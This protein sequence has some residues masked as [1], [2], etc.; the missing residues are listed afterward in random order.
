VTNTFSRKPDLRTSEPVAVRSRGLS[1]R[2]GDN[3]ALE[4]LS[5][6]VPFGAFVGLL[7]P[8]G[9]GKTTS[10]HCLTTLVEPSTG[11]AWIAGHPIRSSGVAIRRDIGVVFQS[12][13]LDPSL[14]VEETLAFAGAIRGLPRRVSRQRAEAMLALFRLDATRRA[15][16]ATL[17]GGTR[18]A[19]DIARSV[20]HRPRILFLDEP[21]LG[22]DVPNRRRIWDHIARLRRDEGATVFFTTHYLDEANDCDAVHFIAGGRIVGSGSP[23]DLMARMG[24]QMLEIEGHGIEAV[25]HALRP[26]L[27]PCFLEGERALFRFVGSPE[28]TEL[29]LRSSFGDLRS[30]RRRRPTLEDVFVWMTDPE[31]RGELS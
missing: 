16:V 1:K 6:E 15:R 13:A 2:Y 11:S 20:I 4:D 5:L 10:M 28:Q 23:A 27:G 26:E 24:S 14:T 22:L 29:R 7:G 21:T 25:A 8:N 17:S 18:R 12:P 31:L 19:V 3:V 30:V 9:S